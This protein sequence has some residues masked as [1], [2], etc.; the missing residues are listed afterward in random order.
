MSKVR[1]GC[2]GFLLLLGAVAM[3]ALAQ[4]R[5]AA[6]SEFSSS[7][8]PNDGAALK[9]AITGNAI[10]YIYLQRGVYV[11]SN[12]VVIDRTTSLFIHGA[13]RMATMLVARDP[14]QPLFVV[15]SAPLVNFAGVRLYP[16][17]QTVSPPLNAKATTITSTA[18]VSLEF[19]DCFID[20]A[21]LEFTG[22]GTYRV[23]SCAFDPRGRARTGVLVDH[24]GADV[25]IFG[26]D[27]S[28]GQDRLLSDAYAHVWQKR[29][30]LRVYAT[31]VEAGLGPADFR[32]ET[33]SALGPHVIASVRSE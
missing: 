19:Q 2:A 18:P 20:S 32:I 21:T 23:Q 14:S 15:R 25:L 30:Q 11:L 12:P 3:P 26:G 7:V 27:I 8:A 5:P 22:P 13:D 17:R 24:P 28:N 1:R 10:K 4:T 16:T 9:Q 31:T 6:Y 33:A 29:G